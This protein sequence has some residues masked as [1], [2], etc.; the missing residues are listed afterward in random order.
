MIRAGIMS[1]QRIANYGSI[2]QAYALKKLLEELGCEVEFADYHIGTPVNGDTGRNSFWRKVKKLNE[3]F[4]VGL[5]FRQTM[6]YLSFKKNFRKNYWPL[7]G[8]TE[9]KNYNPK[10][11]LLVI[12]SDEVF[13]CLQDNFRT[14][15]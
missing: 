8:I 14:F 5:S 7:L 3:A 9:E 6:K 12:G 1:M 15:V 4:E 10:L 13:N 11:D 2:L